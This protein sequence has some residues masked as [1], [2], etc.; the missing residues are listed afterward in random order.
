MGKSRVRTLAVLS[1]TELQEN[2]YAPQAV[3][4]LRRDVE[5]W[6][7]RLTIRGYRLTLELEVLLVD[8][9]LIGPDETQGWFLV[10]DKRI[11]YDMLTGWVGALVSMAQLEEESE[12]RKRRMPKP[13][14]PR[15][16][17]A[18]AKP[19][20]APEPEDDVQDYESA[21]ERMEATLKA[22]QEKNGIGYY[23]KD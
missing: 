19:T 2:L 7:R 6:F 17:A 15:A 13:K 20:A 22:V 21:R 4:R 11:G 12:A 8:A 14:Q 9:G 1:P 16:R 5:Q 23:N 18:V 10:G 3:G